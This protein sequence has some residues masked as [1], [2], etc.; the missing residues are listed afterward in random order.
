MDGWFAVGVM[1]GGASVAGLQ[2]A[3][4]TIDLAR[5]RSRP[6][7]QEV[8][9]MQYFSDS[10]LGERP[11]TVA[12]ISPTL[13]DGIAW[14]IQERINDGSFRSN[15]YEK[16]WESKKRFN[17]NIKS[18]I[19]ALSGRLDQ[20]SRIGQPELPVTM[21]I[22][23][24]CWKEVGKYE[25][26]NNY[27]YTGQGIENLDKQVGQTEFREAIN[28]LFQR[29]GIAFTLTEQGKIERLIPGPVG[30]ALRSA[31]FQTGDAQL[32]QLLETARLKILVPDESGR[33]DALEKLWDAWERLKT[34]EDSDKKTGAEKMLNKSAGSAQP[35]FR[36]LLDDEARAL[37]AAGNKL[38]IRHSETTQER[39][40]ESEQ[41]DYLFQRMFSLIHL[42]LRVTGR[43]G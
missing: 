29:N 42:I 14:L 12:E 34:I 31:V 5:N 37:T 1:G 13:W 7:D 24:F 38:G 17:A 19:P 15:P 30:S 28:F 21:D 6:I 20:I 40:E 43:V 33:R 35:T 22:I 10:E 41:V 25:I 9:R 11:R 18:Q 8:I 16:H 26:T 27:S 2:F 39:L 23:Q 4:D 36:S 32:D 3:R